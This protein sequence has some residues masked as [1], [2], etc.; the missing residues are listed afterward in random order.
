VRGHARTLPS[1]IWKCSAA[2]VTGS[3]GVRQTGD[4][5]R[6]PLPRNRRLYCGARS[7]SG[8]KATQRSP[9]REDAATRRRASSDGDH[10]LPDGFLLACRE[11]SRRHGW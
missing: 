8:R 11:E 3:G 4:G 9:D 1:V 5:A 7:G 10:R 2:L 6:P